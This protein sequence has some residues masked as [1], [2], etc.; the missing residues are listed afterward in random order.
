MSVWIQP[1]SYSKLTKPNPLITAAYTNQSKLVTQLLHR[2]PCIIPLAPRGERHWRRWDSWKDLPN[3]ARNSLLK[4]SL[5]LTL[6]F[7]HVA[8]VFSKLHIVNCCLMILDVF[9]CIW[10]PVNIYN[11]PVAS[12]TSE[13]IT[14]C[15]STASICSHTCPDHNRIT[16]CLLSLGSSAAPFIYFYFLP[17]FWTAAWPFCWG[18]SRVCN[19]WWVLWG[20]GRVRSVCSCSPMRKHVYLHPGEDSRLA[21]QKYKGFLQHGND[22]PL[23]RQDYL[24]A[25][26]I[27]LISFRTTP[28]ESQRQLLNLHHLWATNQLCSVKRRCRRNIN[29]GSKASDYLWTRT[30]HFVLNWLYL[31]QFLLHWYNVTQIKS[32]I[33]HFL[34]SYLDFHFTQKSEELE[35]HSCETTIYKI[36]V[37]LNVHS[38]SPA[39]LCVLHLVHLYSPS[40]MFLSFC[41]ADCET[42]CILYF[43]VPEQDDQLLLY[44]IIF[45][46]LSRTVT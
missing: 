12:A 18:L 2:T 40:N 43:F 38:Y 9:V 33:W 21:V 27:S 15:H 13:I 45:A 5:I 19:L 26:H 31:S 20:L 41:F 8:H 1:N 10:A 46:L 24:F 25:F 42:L 11:H 3:K 37:Q 7:L 35:T 6:E 28:T 39:T 29:S 36:F 23:T 22:F 17:A 30:V 34:M 32:E 4:K 14:K 44:I 16:L